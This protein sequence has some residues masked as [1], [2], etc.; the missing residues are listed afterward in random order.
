M[1]SNTNAFLCI[2]KDFWLIL[3]LI[4]FCRGADKPTEHTFTCRAYSNAGYTS[5]FYSASVLKQLFDYYQDE[6]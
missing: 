6:D 5:M 2:I 1:A 4:S 3:H